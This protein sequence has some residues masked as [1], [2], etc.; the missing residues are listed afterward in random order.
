MMRFGELYADCRASGLDRTPSG[1]TTR[2][3]SCALVLPATICAHPQPQSERVP[4]ARAALMSLAGD[5]LP[6]IARSISGVVTRT[7]VIATR[8]EYP[9]MEQSEHPTGM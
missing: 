3:S 1:S 4:D 9:V 5:S 8:P 6:A 7:S 2:T